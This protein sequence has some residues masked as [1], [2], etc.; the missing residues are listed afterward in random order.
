MFSFMSKSSGASKLWP[1]LKNKLLPVVVGFI[2][3]A[4]PRS[5][6]KSME[7]VVLA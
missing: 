4:L 2:V 7:T 6:D 1:N 5:N 3:A